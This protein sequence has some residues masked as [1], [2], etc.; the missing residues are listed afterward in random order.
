[1]HAGGKCLVIFMVDFLFF[2]VFTSTFMGFDVFIIHHNQA[3]FDLYT[4]N[5][6]KTHI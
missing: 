6:D 4:S 3:V 5:N 1:M 2:G